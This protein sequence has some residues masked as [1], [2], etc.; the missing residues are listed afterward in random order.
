MN[1]KQ[2]IQVTHKLIRKE[3]Q[4]DRHF[5]LQSSL[6]NKNADIRQTKDQYYIKEEN[7]IDSAISRSF[8]RGVFTKL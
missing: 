7:Y 2:E 1:C 8:Y 4:T 6:A 3:G 5:K